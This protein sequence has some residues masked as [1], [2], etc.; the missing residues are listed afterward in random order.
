MIS[1]LV[2]LYAQLCCVCIFP[3]I[4]TGSIQFVHPSHNQTLSFPFKN[5]TKLIQRLEVKIIHKARFIYITVKIVSTNYNEISKTKYRRQQ[6]QKHQ[7]NMFFEI[8]I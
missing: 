1:P 7:K 6:Q 2:Q 3:I 5:R 4:H 8:I